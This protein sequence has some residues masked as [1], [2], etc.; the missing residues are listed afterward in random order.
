M[1]IG[2]QRL[3]KEAPLL[4]IRPAKIDDM[5]KIAQFI[6][7]SAKWYEPFVDP[8][9]MSEHKPGSKWI[10]DNY[11]KRDFYIAKTPEREIGTIS[12]QF[13]G[14]VAYLGY[15]YLDASQ[16]GRGYGH[17]L[18]DHARAIC[19]S[20]PG[21]NKMCLIAHPK[22]TWAVRAYEKYGFHRIETQKEK[23]LQYNNGFMKPYY[24]EGFHLYEYQL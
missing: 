6:A 21:V 23:I 18:L 14:Q 24:E 16:A 10:K 9:D 11:Q 19:L 12:T 4:I 13:F 5:P 2:Y 8:K 15:V 22:A 1:K 3:L 7:S 20:K 17:K